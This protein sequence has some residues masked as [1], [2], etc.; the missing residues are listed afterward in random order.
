MLFFPDLNHHHPH[1][2]RETGGNMYASQKLRPRQETWIF[3][4]QVWAVEALATAFYLLSQANSFQ[5]R[6]IE[7]HAAEPPRE[8]FVFS[9]NEMSG[10]VWN[11]M[12]ANDENNHFLDEPSQ[13]YSSEPKI[14]ALLWYLALI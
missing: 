14:M 13:D 9:M 10:L 8:V 3:D 4:T 1:Y 7:P 11:E 12:E 5:S 6:T 2:Q